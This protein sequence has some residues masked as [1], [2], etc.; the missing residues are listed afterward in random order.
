M[1]K[2]TAKQRQLQQPGQQQQSPAQQHGSSSSS[3]EE[4]ANAA[5]VKTLVLQTSVFV[6]ATVVAAYFG[7]ISDKLALAIIAG[8]CL[9]LRFFAT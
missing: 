2:Q 6:A 4:A 8:M 7:L 5:Q 3:S 1:G 9:C